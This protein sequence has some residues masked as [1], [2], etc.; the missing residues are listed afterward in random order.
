VTTGIPIFLGVLLSLGSS[1]AIS[2][3][4]AGYL[5]TYRRAFKAGDR[6]EDRRRRAG[7]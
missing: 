1:S 7:G 3:P 4:I 2:N 5:L 6:G